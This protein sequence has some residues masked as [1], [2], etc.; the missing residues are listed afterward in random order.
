MHIYLHS[1]LINIDFK[2]MLVKDSKHTHT[3]TFARMHTNT[4][5]PIWINSVNI[6]NIF[7]SN[8]IIKRLRS[9]FPFFMCEILQAKHMSPWQQHS[10]VRPSSPVWH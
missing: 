2:S 3:L 10:L 4:Y 1:T 5:F 6:F 7:P 9:T 8:N